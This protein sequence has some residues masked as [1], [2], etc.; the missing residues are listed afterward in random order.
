M[1]KMNVEDAE[2]LVLEGLGTELYNIKKIIYDVAHSTGCEQ[3]LIT[4]GFKILK[5][6]VFWWACIQ[7]SSWR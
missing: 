5:T 2:R 3:L 6:F 1:A 7:A 4:Y